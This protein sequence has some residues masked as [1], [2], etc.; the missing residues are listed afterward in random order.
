MVFTT[1]NLAVALMLFYMMTAIFYCNCR[2][3]ECNTIPRK[4]T[5]GINFRL[6][7][8]IT[9]ND[10]ITYAGS[11][12]PA[13]DSIRLKDIVSG[14]SYPLFISKGVNET[15]IYSAHYVRP[16]NM[17]DTLEFKFGNFPLDTLIVYTGFVKGWRGDECPTVNDA[18]IRKITLRGQVLLET[19]EDNALFTILK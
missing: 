6:K 16:A 3:E 10:I 7:D 14:Q 2:K 1:P 15:I 13:P 17:I 11:I 19:D 5:I 4:Q 9:G 12:Q 18:G 8:G